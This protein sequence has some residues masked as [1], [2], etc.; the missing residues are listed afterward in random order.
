MHKSKGDIKETNQ[1]IILIIITC[2]FS[3][4]FLKIDCN[5][6]FCF[7]LFILLGSVFETAFPMD[8]SSASAFCICSLSSLD[9]SKEP[10]GFNIPVRFSL[11]ATIENRID[12]LTFER[13][14]QRHLHRL[15]GKKSSVSR[16][17]PLVKHIYSRRYS[18]NTIR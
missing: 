6:T 10:C 11:T 1:S 4:I 8:K 13:S 12:K 7:N 15:F 14:R 16:R 17:F 2:L 5:A 18:L 3:S 9:R